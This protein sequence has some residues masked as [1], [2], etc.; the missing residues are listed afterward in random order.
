MNYAHWLTILG[1]VGGVTTV[2]FGVIGTAGET[3]DRN[4]GQLTRYGRLAILGILVGALIS[5]TGDYLKRQEEANAAIRQAQRYEQLIRRTDAIIT[6]A[7]Q[8]RVETTLALKK[9]QFAADA[10]TRGANSSRETLHL[11]NVAISE[12]AHNAA[13]T[14]AI[15]DQAKFILA[16]TSNNVDLSKGILANTV[17]LG[18]GIK[19]TIKTGESTLFGLTASLALGKATLAEQERALFTMV[20]VHAAVSLSV[21][22][23][24]PVFGPYER[25]LQTSYN[26]LAGVSGKQSMAKYPM[27][28]ILNNGKQGYVVINGGSALLPNSSM[29]ESPANRALSPVVYVWLLNQRVEQLPTAR[30]TDLG[31]AFYDPGT[32]AYFTATGADVGRRDSFD[33]ELHCDPPSLAACTITYGRLEVPDV[34][35]HTEYLAPGGRL[36]ILSLSD[37]VGGTI[38]ITIP[39]VDKSANGLKLDWF[40]LN[41]NG[42]SIMFRP[43]TAAKRYAA[44]GTL[45]YRYDVPVTLSKLFAQYR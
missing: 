2:F 8:I 37:V 43:E 30:N 32:V 21:D 31:Y 10:A 33:Y 18:T 36:P 28:R 22:L 16:K 17:Q 24:S 15:Q 11:T 39:I 42:T 41:I 14:H 1:F 9:T 27:S 12:I 45:V 5:Q 26:D 20:N 35:P 23:S 25:R 13:R 34:P 3:R 38:F 4:T 19:Q 40:E 29:A 7:T 6:Q 44:N